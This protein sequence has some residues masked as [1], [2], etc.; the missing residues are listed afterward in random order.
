[1]KVFLKT[2]WHAISYHTQI[3]IDWI[4]TRPVCT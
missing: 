3:T 1:M 2:K 4:K